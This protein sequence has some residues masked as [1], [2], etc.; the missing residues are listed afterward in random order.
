MTYKINIL[1]NASDDLD[2]FRKNDR[3]SYVKIFDLV[4]ELME[5]PRN[6]IGK[7]ERLKYF[8]KEVY[9]RRV[10]H[11]DRLINTIYESVR[12]IDISSCRGHYE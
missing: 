1:D 10:N 11:K 7:P 9:S 12:E 6:G 8:E 5:D 4:R 2:W 3:T